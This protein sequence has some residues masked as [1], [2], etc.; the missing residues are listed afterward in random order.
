M[1]KLILKTV[2]VILLAL[3]AFT[4]FYSQRPE[5]GRTPTGKR[6]ERI[7]KS[8][9]YYKGRFWAINP[10]EKA[11]ETSQ[12]EATM[13]FV[14]GETPKRLVPAGPVVSQ[15][16]DLHKLDPKQDVVIWMGHSTYYM[17]LNGYK[18]LIDPVFSNWAS[19]LPFINKAFPGSNIYTAEDIPDIDVLVISHDHWDHLDYPTLTALKPKIKKVVIP[20][21]IGEHFEYWGYDV[22]KIVEE[23]W[24]TAVKINDGLTVHILPAQHFTG[25]FLNQNQSEPCAYAFVAP[26]KKVFYSGDGGY[27][28]EFKE[29]GKTFDG[30]DLAI[31]E[32][33][34]Y[35]KDW[36]N[37]HM[38]PAQTAQAGDDLKA[39]TVLPAHSG[40]FALARH[41][42]DE[43]YI[44]LAEESKTKHYKLITP[45][46]G[47][48]AEIGNTAQTFSQWWKE[49]K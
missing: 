28:K 5:F 46:I 10:I 22:S 45:R 34:Q 12:F 23:D 31:L 30:F 15:K 32:N 33:G 14:F 11:V 6:L 25:R 49:M 39:R 41:S 44:R 13:R 18:I 24:Y 17:Q 4:Y 35:N 29:F 48:A 43:P 9:H 26:A 27:T 36:P 2:F 16:T 42:W 47:E 1:L 8:P 37:I 19:P 21:G 7:Q 3:A 40:K 38:S 20:L